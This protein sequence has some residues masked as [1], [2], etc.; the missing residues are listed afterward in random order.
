MEAPFSSSGVTSNQVP[1]GIGS[2]LICTKQ[3]VIAGLLPVCRR[4]QLHRPT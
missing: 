2:L 1:G 3:H 4:R